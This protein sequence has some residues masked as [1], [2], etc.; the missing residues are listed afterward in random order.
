MEV[1]RGGCGGQR[2]ARL[3]FSMGAPERKW[4]C[5]FHRS[6]RRL[7]MTLNAGVKLKPGLSHYCQRGK[8]AANGRGVLG[9]RAHFRN[10]QRPN[11]A[12]K[13]KWFWNKCCRGDNGRRGVEAFHL[14]FI[15]FRVKWSSLFPFMLLMIV[16]VWTVWGWRTSTWHK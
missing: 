5:F 12:P 16:L 4:I 15:K 7:E 9:A 8:K 2:D 3:M 1:E 10:N 11:A 14:A 13:W 6:P